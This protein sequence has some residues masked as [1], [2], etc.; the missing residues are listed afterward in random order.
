M[1]DILLLILFLAAFVIIAFEE[2]IDINKAKVGMFFGTLAWIIL[3]VYYRFIGKASEIEHAFNENILEIATLWLF[4]IAAMTFIAYMDKRGFIENL[5]YN[6]LPKKISERKLLLIIGL[7][8]F[9]VSSLIDNLTATLIAITAIL[10]LN[11]D[12]KKLIKF[13]VFIVFAANAG[14]VWL[15]T[16]DITTLMLFIGDK[17]EMA[18]LLVMIIPGL[19]SLFVL[20]F[21]LI[22]GMNGTIT[23]DKAEKKL[24][25]VDGMIAA[26]FIMTI[27]GIIL[28]NVFLGIPPMLTFIF[29]LSAMFLYAWFHKKK[30]NEDLQILDY[31]RAIEFNSLFFFLGVLLLVG[32]LKEVGVLTQILK[33]YEFL[34]MTVA[35]YCMGIASAFVDNIPLTAALMKSGVELG[36]AGWLSLNYAVGVGGSILAIGSA[37]G[38]V[39]MGKIKK[40]T[41]GAYFRYS[42]H[43]LIAYTVGFF[44]AVGITKIWI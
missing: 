1:I 44:V 34:P 25:K 33:L 23:F 41:F 5:F 10:S 26:I 3:F 36:E 35:S 39:A 38:V 14:G 21:L 13:G 27:I 24:T 8:T 7:F 20:Y 6:K 30:N 11:F 42:F 16:G 12:G 18:P 32:M 22:R 17:V 29:G 19:I 37:A 43:V 9:F 31:I 15:I 2:R 40:L 28:G 4:L